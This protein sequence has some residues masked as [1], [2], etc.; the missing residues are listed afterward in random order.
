[1]PIMIWIAIIIQAAILNFL[2]MG[3]LLGIQFANASIGWCVQV[4]R[5]RSAVQPAAGGTAGRLGTGPVLL[6]GGR[7]QL[8]QR[9]SAAPPQLAGTAICHSTRLD[10]PRLTSP[11]GTRTGTRQQSLL[12]PSP[13]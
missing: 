13:P 10:S 9:P 11:R 12:M 2:D 8:Q 1:M 6:I 7:R 3:I 5:P 4:L